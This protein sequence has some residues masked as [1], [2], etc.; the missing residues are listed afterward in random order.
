MLKFKKSSL[1]LLS[2]IICIMLSVPAPAAFAV[3]G[4]EMAEDLDNYFIP[5]FPIV[6]GEIIDSLPAEGLAGVSSVLK[7]VEIFDYIYKIGKI[8][9]SL[10]SGTAD[11]DTALDSATVAANLAIKFMADGA[12]KKILIAGVGVGTLP[13]TALITSIDIARSS[14]KAV[15][16]SKIALDLERL[17]YSVEA[18]PVLRDRNRKLGTGNPIKTDAAAVEYLF[19]KCLREQSWSA[20]FKT[21]VTTELGQDWPEPSLWDRLTVDNDFL[22]EAAILAEKNRLKSH[23]TSLLLELN[24]VAQKQEARVV[25]AKQSQAIR[26]MAGKISP[27]ELRKALSLYQ[28]ALKELPDIQK[29]VESLP[30]KIRQYEET[31]KKATA[32]ELEKMRVEKLPK[33]MKEIVTCMSYVKYLP[34]KGSHSSMRQSLLEKLK[35]FYTTLFNLKNNVSIELINTRLEEEVKVLT[36]QG[37]LFEFIRYPCPKFFEDYLPAIEADVKAGLPPGELA[38]IFEEIEE[39]RKTLSDSYDKDYKA[40]ENLF[41]EKIQEFDDKINEINEK[42]KDVKNRIATTSETSTLNRLRETLNTLE[43]TLNGLKGERKKLMEKFNAYRTMFQDT[44]T[45]DLSQCKK[46]IDEINQYIGAYANKFQNIQSY[47]KE[48]YK[49]ALSINTEFANS[50][51]GNRLSEG[52]LSEEEIDE[53]KDILAKN[54]GSVYAYLDL[55]FLKDLVQLQPDMVMSASFQKILED[56]TEAINHTLKQVAE[57]KVTVIRDWSLWTISRLQYMED[58]KSTNDI[59]IVID[60]V[61]KALAEFHSVDPDDISKSYKAEYDENIRILEIIKEGMDSYKKLKPLAGGLASQ[62]EAYIAQADGV[63]ARVEEDRIYLTNVYLQFVNAKDRLKYS[64][65]NA[66]AKSLSAKRNADTFPTGISGRTIKDELE[67]AGI[68]NFSRKR[69]LG[70][71]ALFKEPFIDISTDSGT[72]SIR[73]EHLNNVL[74]GINDLP[75]DSYENYQPAYAALKEKEGLEGIIFSMTD[76][77]TKFVNFFSF[78]S[79]MQKTAEKIIKK[80][81]EK[82]ERISAVVTK[83][84]D[85]NALFTVLKN[86]IDHLIK[87]SN[88]Q[89]AMGNFSSVMVLG[90]QA[91]DLKIEYEELDKTDIKIDEAF[92]ELAALIALAKEKYIDAQNRLNTDIDKGLEVIKDFYGDFKKAYESMDDYQVMNLIDEDWEAGDGTTL[93]DLEMNLSR[94]FRTFDEIQYSISNLKISPL[95]QDTYMVT[96]DINITSRMFSRNLKHEEKSSVSE[97]VGIDDKGRVKIIRTLNG[98]FWQE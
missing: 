97:E 33:D 52:F 55:D 26:A 23:I 30:E 17:Y 70:I 56:L 24:K 28:T 68:L 80:L 47:L 40:N 98:R 7:G 57:S 25:V 46:I 61:D 27:E 64:L 20:L 59:N 77:E 3:N 4:Q 94:T 50:H 29:Y 74:S 75:V 86:K 54:T 79:G 35:N 1:R 44:A 62:L 73:S 19:R 58:S 76:F 95:P 43:Q 92:K 36:V 69:S 10:A 12:T 81:K 2:L 31:G 15:A 67:S 8:G 14:S 45:I 49:N 38:K 88:D 51:S 78:D 96:Y 42:I 89:I 5:A 91:D 63:N 13:L 84:D 6:Y 71:E 60:S 90:T 18:N 48:C 65:A 93:T 11:M 72:V 21:Y 87:F 32:V 66:M 16:Q 22:E 83:A 85:E 9:D 53:I 34:T 39:T 82:K 37:Q 41:N